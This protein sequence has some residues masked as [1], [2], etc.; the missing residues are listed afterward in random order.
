MKKFRIE[1]MHDSRALLSEFNENSK[2]HMSVVL[3]DS[4]NNLK[5]L[6]E[7]SKR[8]MSVVLEDFNNSLKVFKEVAPKIPTEERIKEIVREE[9]EPLRSD[10]RLCINEIGQINKKLD[11]HERR[12]QKLELVAV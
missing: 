1:S 8:H 7:N 11:Y 9:I 2:R 4:K 12:I 5:E 6:N 3:G 10:V